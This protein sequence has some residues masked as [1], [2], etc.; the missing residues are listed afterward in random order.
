MEQE[1]KHHGLT[2][3]AKRSNGYYRCRK[4]AVEAVQRRRS[5]VKVMS[6]EYMGGRCELCGY[7]KYIGALEFH[8]LNPD[9]KEFNI[10]HDGKT[11]SWEKIK[12]E[13]D[14]C[15]LLCANCHREIHNI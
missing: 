13:L 2:K 5:K 11:R 3:F 8:H 6:V 4:C 1:C 9:E 10:S 14:K 15:M 12:V 7:S